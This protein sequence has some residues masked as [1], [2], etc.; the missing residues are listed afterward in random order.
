MARDA[1]NQLR[2]IRDTAGWREAAKVAGIPKR[3]AVAKPSNAS[4]RGFKT[5]SD[6]NRRDRLQRLIGGQVRADG[7]RDFTKIS[8]KTDKG[9]R[10]AMSDG[11]KY[12]EARL[13]LAVQSLNREK[14]IKRDLV[15]TTTISLTDDEKE[16]LLE[17]TE[18]LD[19]AEVE[20]LRGH[21]DRDDWAS[22]KAE[23]DSIM[24]DVQGLSV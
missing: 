24:S 15:N 3:I 10:T 20:S 4:G 2:A 6:K 5:L 21:L 22:F 23:Y 14:A 8:K 18:P 12:K 9:I 13:V 17:E 16:V 19:D 1:R 11:D 7:S